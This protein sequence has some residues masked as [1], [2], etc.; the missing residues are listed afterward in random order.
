MTKFSKAFPHLLKRNSAAFFQ[1]LPIH[2]SWLTGY[3]GFVV[4]RDLEMLKDGF[5]VH[6]RMR[7]SLGGQDWR[8]AEQFKHGRRLR[9][10]GAHQNY[11]SR[12]YHWVQIVRV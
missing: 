1:E 5:Q 11:G 6:W 4:Q 9:K 10:R 2:F 7:N 12:L 3:I 8:V